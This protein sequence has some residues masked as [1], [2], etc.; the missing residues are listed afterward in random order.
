[1]LN[2]GIMNKNNKISQGVKYF[3]VI[4]SI[5]TILI[6]LLSPAFL[7][8]ED[9]DF[10]IKSSNFITFSWQKFLIYILYKIKLT[11]LAIFIQNII[12]AICSAFIIVKI[13]NNYNIFIK[14]KYLDF[15][16]KIIPF[17]SF[18]ILLSLNFNLEIVLYSFLATTFFVMLF[19]NNKQEWNNSYLFLFIMLSIIISSWTNTGC[20][21]LI[22]SILFI[23]FS[24]NIQSYLK[25]I[26]VL[27]LVILSTFSINYLSNTD[28]SN[29]YNE[30]LVNNAIKQPKE[31]ITNHIS[32]YNL[33][34]AHIYNSG[35]NH[36][37]KFTYYIEN[38]NGNTV[39]DKIT[40][41]LAC[42]TNFLKYKAFYKI[43][44][45]ISIPLT[46]FIVLNLYF[47]LRK[48]WFSFCITLSPL[49]VTLAS[50][51]SCSNEFYLYYLPIILQ[52]HIV[53]LFFVLWI[54]INYK[55]ILE[56]KIEIK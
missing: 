19:C 42:Q 10:F 45:S 40:S 20:I 29:D 30:Q 24:K 11:Y 41:I 31:Y 14:N 7:Y 9:T 16:I 6:F 35:F 50:F 23:I 51:L 44:Y 8:S 25:K 36:N 12:I 17:L 28:Y 27:I 4:A 56:Y 21:Y 52:G 47:L 54:F 43:L 32:F 46:I 38:N 26:I 5:L 15:I 48:Q 2:I 33:S 13:E 1:M 39:C 55:K 49:L 34:D 53:L 37:L 3:L 22:T 18:P